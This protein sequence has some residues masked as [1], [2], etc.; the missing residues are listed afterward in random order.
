VDNFDEYE[1]LTKTRDWAGIFKLNDTKI[2]AL[3]TKKELG[4]LA[5]YLEDGEVVFALASGVMSQTGTSNSFDFG[6]N[7][8]LAALTNERILLLDHAM[9]SSSVDTQSVRHDRIQAVSASQGWVLGKIMV[10]IGNRSIK[11]DN[12]QKAHVSIFASLANRWLKEF[13]KP[14]SSSTPTSNNPIDELERLAKLKM[15]GILDESEFA[16]AKAKILAR[17]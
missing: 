2:D 6:T 12:C 15:A 4:V 14:E 3:G 10:D 16:A 1:R 7:T 9:L 13:Q 5:N 17:I 11:I 8:W